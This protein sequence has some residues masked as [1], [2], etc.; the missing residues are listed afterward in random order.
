M[1]W[2]W[3]GSITR[4]EWEDTHAMSGLAGLV[5]LTKSPP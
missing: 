2:Y 1:C 5:E 3:V 4:Y